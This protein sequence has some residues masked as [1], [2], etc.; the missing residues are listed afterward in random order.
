MGHHPSI[1]ARLPPKVCRWYPFVHLGHEV[2]NVEKRFLSKEITQHRSS[3]VVFRSR[4]CIEGR[5]SHVYTR[6]T[7]MKRG[8]DNYKFK[9][10]SDLRKPKVGNSHSATANSGDWLSLKLVHTAFSIELS[11][12]D[13]SSITRQ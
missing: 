6:F 1:F 3:L 10:F 8:A 2:E 13:K 9:V 5:V 11:S 12:V 7:C 4:K